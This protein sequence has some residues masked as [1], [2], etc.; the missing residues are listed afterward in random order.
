MDRNLKRLLQQADEK[1]AKFTIIVGERDI[2]KEEVSIRN[3]ST[4][5]TEQV[6]IKDAVDYIVKAL[7]K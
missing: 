7:G 6:K 3:M 2:A 4:K 1:N 5:E